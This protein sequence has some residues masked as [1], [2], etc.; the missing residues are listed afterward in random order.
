LDVR[1]SRE[2]IQWECSCTTAVDVQPAA[3]G[4]ADAPWIVRPGKGVWYRRRAEQS[5]YA[6]LGCVLMGRILVTD[7]WL[8]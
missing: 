1:K 5:R 7:T 6:C 8:K 3:T 4:K 2:Y